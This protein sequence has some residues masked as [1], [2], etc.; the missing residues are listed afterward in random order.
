MSFA[1]L[2]IVALIEAVAHADRNKTKKEREEQKRREEIRS[3]EARLQLQMI[4]AAI[5]LN[6]I[7]AKKV[8]HQKTNGDVEDANNAVEEA[9]RA[10][11]D[12]INRIALEEVNHKE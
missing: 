3:E 4:N 1:G 11:Y 12:F 2:I 8:Q 6:K 10:Y 7:I 5:K 9:Q